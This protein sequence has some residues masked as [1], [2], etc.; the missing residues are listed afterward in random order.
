MKSFTRFALR[1]GIYFIV[2]GYICADLFLFNGP[3]QRRILASH[4]DSPES[5]AKA[6]AEGVVARVFG[7]KITRSQL[8]RAVHERLFLEGTSFENLG[9]NEKKMVEYAAL[10]DLI[11]HELMRVKVKV[12]SNKLKVTDEEIDARLERFSK[13][14]L[15]REELEK[16]MRSQGI[17]SMGALR[18]RIA[19][20][21]QQEKYVALRVDPLCTVSEQEI[22]DFYQNH[23]DELMIPARIRVRHIFIPT[24]DT[25]ASEAK[26][27]LETALS[28]LRNGSETFA[29]LARSISKDPATSEHAGDLGWMSRSR[30]PEDF[31]NATF[32]LP[33]DQPTLIQTKIGLHIVEVTDR[34]PAEIPSLEGIR[35]EIHTA[36]TTAK[37][38]RAVNDFRSALRRFEEQKID[39]FHD[40]L[41]R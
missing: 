13:T 24:L 30:L 3:I 10:G 36:L 25:P 33:L 39:I 38:H 34:R 9:P 21:I 29:Q 7:H 5:I 37:R 4:P 19:A 14:F 17:P 32:D 31:A 23:R 1:L 27:T 22:I 20:R 2:V 6:K 12:N 26:E 8:H 41:G 40:Q 15:T 28:H 16:A 35:T 11:D 18:N